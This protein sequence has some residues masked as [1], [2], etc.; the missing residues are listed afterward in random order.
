LL[1]DREVA[2][3]FHKIW[4][5]SNEIGLEDGVPLARGAGGSVM[6]NCEGASGS[7]SYGVSPAVAKG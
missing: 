3:P 2:M 4:Y 1:S 5:S 7:G 6:A